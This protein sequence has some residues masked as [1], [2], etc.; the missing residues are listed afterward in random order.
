MK[1]DLKITIICE[2]YNQ[3]RYLPHKYIAENVNFIRLNK[4][5]ENPFLFFTCLLKIFNTYFTN[6]YVIIA[7]FPLSP[8]IIFYFPL[9]I[10]KH[11]KVVYETSHPNWNENKYPIELGPLKPVLKKI[12]LCFLK[13]L[14]I[15]TVNLPSYNYLKKISDETS[16]IPHCVD[17]SVFYDNPKIEKNNKFTILF[18]G[19]IQ[20][21]KG[22]D[23]LIKAAKEL[24]D[25]DFWLVGKGN[26]EEN[27]KKSGLKNIKLLGF[28][29]DRDKLNKIYNKCHCL[30]LPS[31]RIKSGWEELF[32]IVIIEAMA[33]RLPVIASDCI[34]PKEIITDGE[35]GLLFKKGN[36]S[37]LLDLITLLKNDQKL[38][39]KIQ[40]N[41]LKK[42][43]SRYS[44]EKVSKQM[45][46]FLIQS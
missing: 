14:K 34:G 23:L 40:M 26:Y 13:N 3:S 44:L 36:I 8:L 2:A 46:K 33:A 7:A 16:L 35:D 24:N 30:V 22:I 18:V 32:G 4:L 1:K 28:V 38:R 15:R 12:W 37:K 6:D 11:N 19:K 43:H 25:C 9:K 21:K 31:R 10:F 29:E 20:Y 39:A 42:V 41:A 17:T 45:H 27:V 5:K